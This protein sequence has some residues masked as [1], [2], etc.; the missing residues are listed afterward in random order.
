MIENSAELP[1]G[2][3]S[4]KQEQP[5]LVAEDVSDPSGISSSSNQSNANIHNDA[6]G[7]DGQVIHA[8]KPRAK[9]R[10]RTN[11]MLMALMVSLVIVYLFYVLVLPEIEIILFRLNNPKKR[12][13]PP[14]LEM[15]WASRTMLRSCEFLFVGWFFYFGASIGSFLNVVAW[16][17][18]EG[19]TIVFGGSKC[20]FCDTHLSFID[21]T[22]ILGWLYLQGKCRTC[23]LPIAPRY[24]LIEIAV[25][26]AF[27]WLALWQLV[28]GGA[29]LP[30]WNTFG[31]EGLVN[32]VLD[33]PWPLI[34]IY[35]VHAGMFGILIMLATANTGRKPFPVF[36]LVL[37]ALGLASAKI[38]YPALDVV[39]WNLPFIETGITGFGPRANPAI[40]V[41]VG[42]VAGSLIGWVSSFVFARRFGSVIGRHWVLQC[43]LVG[44]VLGWQSIVTIVVLSLIVYAVLRPAHR[45]I[46][47]KLSNW[48]I[49]NQSLGLNS[50][51]IITALVHHTFWSQL[52]HLLG[53][54]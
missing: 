49:A 28:R 20:P 25:G 17:V 39:A 9:R 54:I 18:P 47:P 21:N 44:T 42:G 10:Q 43:F 24:L 7:Q 45:M 33:P 22:P 35:L 19:R 46:S 4:P 14:E 41:L 6:S 2:A 53:L 36:A 34:S 50:C 32:I 23:R 1:N 26:L 40:S 37:I 48:T 13:L 5:T 27:M 29:N 11:W 15:K 38:I 30:H 51:F 8:H 3:L 12:F 52:A 16:R 31:R